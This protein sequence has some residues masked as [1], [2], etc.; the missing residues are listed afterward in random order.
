MSAQQQA[1]AFADRAVFLPRGNCDF[2]SWI[3]SKLSSSST[4]SFT[5]TAR[6]PTCKQILCD[7]KQCLDEKC[8]Q[9]KH[10]C[11]R[12]IETSTHLT[13]GTM[14]AAERPEAITRHLKEPCLIK[15]IPPR[16]KKKATPGTTFF[17][18]FASV[19]PET[20]AKQQ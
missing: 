15:T 10:S 1:F 9:L 4:L 13:H 11:A 7:D 16:Q 17:S 18:C 2:S 12:G 8:A 20:T 19:T 5:A 14:P 6:T 3:C